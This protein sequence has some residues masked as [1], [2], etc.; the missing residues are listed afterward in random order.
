MIIDERHWWKIQNQRYETPEIKDLIAQKERLLKENP[1][2]R[3]LQMEIDTL[4][5]A[6][7]DPSVR[8]EILGMLIAEKLNTLQEAWMDVVHAIDRV[9]PAACS[10]RALS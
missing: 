10:P 4:L 3:E 6:T 8:L 9:T 1:R 5:G 7:L 2:L